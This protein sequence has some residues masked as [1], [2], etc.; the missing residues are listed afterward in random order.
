[1]KEVLSFR[2]SLAQKNGGMC[3]WTCLLGLVIGAVNV[4]KFFFSGCRTY[5]SVV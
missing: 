2:N 5:F 4:M 1:M 3:G